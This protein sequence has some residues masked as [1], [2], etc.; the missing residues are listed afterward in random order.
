MA[1]LAVKKKVKSKDTDEKIRVRRT[2]GF[3]D[4][5]YTGSE[6][7]WTIE[8]E[9]LED[10]EYQN[11]II[12]SLNYYNY[13]YSIKDA[14]KW[15]AEYFKHHKDE[16]T[17]ERVSKISKVF[18]LIPMTVF[19]LAKLSNMD[20]PLRASNVVWF[21]NRLSEFESRAEKDLIE[22]EKTETKPVVSIQDRVRETALVMA[23]PIDDAIDEFF[24]NPSTFDLKAVKPVNLLKASQTKGAHAR[25]IKG[26]Y[27]DERERFTELVEGDSKSDEWKELSEGYSNLNK[28]QRKH[29]L[30]F[31]QNIESACDIIIGEAKTVSKRKPKAKKAKPAEELV[32]KLKFK[33][34]D[35]GL[36]IV[37]IPPSKIIGASQIWVY[38]TKTRKLGCYNATADSVGLSVKGTSIIQFNE[39]VSIQKTLRKPL[40]QL[41]DSKDLSRTKMIKWFKDDVKTTD[42]K[43]NGRVGE[44]VVIVKVFQN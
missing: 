42:T 17:T 26:M 2:A 27:V 30:D 10:H 6:I 19:S 33:A 37:S 35:T 11:K 12:R 15:L 40:E 24:Q 41:R 9:A 8:D 13:H 32:K 34:S 39:D 22:E 36:G 20:A 18:D 31:L 4:D 28:V 7:Q 44:D 3:Y 14:Q 29:F 21:N 25:F 1:K 16:W 43:M 23:G 5:K 38:N